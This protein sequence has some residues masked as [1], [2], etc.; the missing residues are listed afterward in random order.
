MNKGD[1]YILNTHQAIDWMKNPVNSDEA[2][3]FKP[4]QI[5]CH[6]HPAN[7]TTDD[8]A[9]TLV[10]QSEWGPE[11]IYMRVCGEC[12]KS[13]PWLFNPLGDEDIPKFERYYL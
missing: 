6:P 4:W 7:C 11:V 2:K 13:Y 12:P 3:D 10:H 8:K 5:Q 9:C 1:V